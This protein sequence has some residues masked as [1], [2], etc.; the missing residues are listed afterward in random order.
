MLVFLVIISSLVTMLYNEVR[1]DIE[2]YIFR[3][4]LWLISTIDT[5]KYWRHLCWHFCFYY[6]DHLLNVSYLY[7]WKI[8]IHKQKKSNSQQLC[9]HIFSH[10]PV[11][12]WWYIME[13]YLTFNA[14]F[15]ETCD[16]LFQILMRRKTT[17]KHV[18]I[19]DYIQHFSHYYSQWSYNSH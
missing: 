6:S 15:S 18:S 7:H 17:N 5:K 2:C 11:K 1:A 19:S 13:L 9:Y 8:P 16:D 3:K 14:R 12:K 4:Y 10:I